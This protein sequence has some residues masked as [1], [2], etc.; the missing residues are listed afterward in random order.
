MDKRDWKRKIYQELWEYLDFDTSEDAAFAA[1]HLDVLER[2]AERTGT[3]LIYL[4]ASDRKRARKALEE[5]K[6]ELEKKGT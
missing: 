4:A 5:V 3:A 1:D 6:L 2:I